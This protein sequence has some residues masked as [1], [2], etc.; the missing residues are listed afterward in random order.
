MF[1][2]LKLL[3]VAVMLQIARTETCTTDSHTEQ[4]RTTVV[5]VTPNTVKLF[6]EIAITK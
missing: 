3:L 1:T 2:V 4:V 6:S 5:G